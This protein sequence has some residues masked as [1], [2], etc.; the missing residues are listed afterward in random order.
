MWLP[1]IHKEF[2]E[3]LS[4]NFAETHLVEH[5]AKICRK[6]SVVYCIFAHFMILLLR[7]SLAL[8]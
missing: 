2:V 6:H 1:S 7:I 4:L 8:S 5:F 3:G